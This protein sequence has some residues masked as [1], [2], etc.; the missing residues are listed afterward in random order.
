MDIGL[1]VPSGG[2]SW[3]IVERAE[4]L[5]RIIHGG[6]EFVGERRLTC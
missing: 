1:G 2:D 3:K 6:L 4:E 5:A